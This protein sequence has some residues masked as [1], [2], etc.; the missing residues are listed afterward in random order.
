MKIAM[1]NM[2]AKDFSRFKY[3][4]VAIFKNEVTERIQ[5]F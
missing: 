2:D 1:D 3:T 5:D 4:S